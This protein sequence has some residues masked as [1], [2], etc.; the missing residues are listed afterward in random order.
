MGNY[1]VK[2]TG[3]VL[4]TF[5][6]SEKVKTG[7]F[8]YAFDGGLNNYHPLNEFRAGVLFRVY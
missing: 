1:V 8:V 2:E 5:K 3:L 7:T 6:K 4:D